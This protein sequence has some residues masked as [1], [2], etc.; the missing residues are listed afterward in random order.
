MPRLKIKKKPTHKTKSKEDD[1]DSDYFGDLIVENDEL[2]AQMEEKDQKIV[3]LNRKIDQLK[4]EFELVEW[5][6][7]VIEGGLVT[8]ELYVEMMKTKEI[9]KKLTKKIDD[10]IIEHKSEM[11]IL[12]KKLKTTQ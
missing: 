11:N 4:N 10:M 5:Y 7:E 9:N 6:T 8:K 2:K 12:N 1:S 3:D